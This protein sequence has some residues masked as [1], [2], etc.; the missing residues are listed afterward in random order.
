[1]SDYAEQEPA[2]EEPV[3][4]TTTKL[5]SVTTLIKLGLGTADPLVNWA[6]N[7]TAGAA[8]DRH[9]I[10]SQFV[11]D[12]EGAVK[13]LAGQRWQKTG[14]AMARGTDLHHAAEKLALGQP[15][16]VEEHVLPYLEQYQRFL[17][18]YRPTFL[19]AEAPVYNATFGYAGTL[20][21]ILELEGE[22]LVADIKTTEPLFREALVYAA[23]NELLSDAQDPRRIADYLGMSVGE[24]AI[25]LAMI[26][27]KLKVAEN[28]RIE[29]MQNYDPTK[30]N[31]ELPTAERG[32]VDAGSEA[33]TL[34]GPESLS[35]LV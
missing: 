32:D 25:H 35:D 7:T 3:P 22:P 11:E 34:S 15:P 18:E 17:E 23:V 31:D 26:R 29:E 16:E 1:M 27:S 30:N 28:K 9:K 19:M 13:W 33:I 10:M 21:G 4:A 5:W 2:V 6:V 20:D 14:K 8:Y 24:V 12:Q